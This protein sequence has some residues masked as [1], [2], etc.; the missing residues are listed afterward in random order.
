MCC[1]VG[2]RREE[3][4]HA[5]ERFVGFRSWARVNTFLLVSGRP[6]PFRTHHETPK[7]DG[8]LLHEGGVVS[9]AATSG[10]EGAK[11]HAPY[12]AIHVGAAAASVPRY[13]RYVFTYT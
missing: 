7:A 1:W 9:L 3:S 11:E 13:V 8:D 12:D 10:W 5:C 4:A 6:I 2:E